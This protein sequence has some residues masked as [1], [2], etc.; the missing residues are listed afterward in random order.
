MPGTMYLDTYPDEWFLSAAK[1]AKTWTGMCS[2][3][4]ERIGRLVSTSTLSN[5]LHKREI[6]E[7]CEKR[8]RWEDSEAQ[9]EPTE[10]SQPEQ[11]FTRDSNESGDTLEATGPRIKTLE[12]LLE[13]ADVDLDTW[14]VERHIINK[15]E[16]F[17]IKFGLT[18]LFQ[19][20]AWL[21]R[22][23]GAVGIT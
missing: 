8:L 6:R 1:G 21:K 16:S 18:E 10:E 9:E 12:Q 4:S 22:K 15:W 7:T 19:V 23:A 20:K 3:L 17:S 14:Y 13:A 11:K 2:V 5:Q